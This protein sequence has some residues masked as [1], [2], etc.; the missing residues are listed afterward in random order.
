MRNILYE[1]VSENSLSSRWIDSY[2]MNQRD[3]FVVEILES[4]FFEMF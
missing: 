3:R 4:W 1:T 2:G